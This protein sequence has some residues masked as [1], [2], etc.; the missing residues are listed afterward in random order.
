MNKNRTNP[1]TDKETPD[2]WDI[3]TEAQL[4]A[5]TIGATHPIPWLINRPRPGLAVLWLVW[6]NTIFNCLSQQSRPS[7]TPAP[8]LPLLLF[9]AANWGSAGVDPG[10]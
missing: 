2:I 4:P 3:G 10:N 5:H 1:L 7:P 6:S 8:K 9:D